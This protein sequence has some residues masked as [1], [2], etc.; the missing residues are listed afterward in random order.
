[1][2][3]NAYA[4][5]M[6][7]GKG[8][9]F[10]PLSTSCRPK[11]LLSLVGN[12]PLVTQAVDRMKGLIP[13][14]RIFVITSSALAAVTR[15]AVPSLPPANIVGEPVP[16]DT[17]AVCA[18]GCALVKARDASAALCILTA[19]HAIGDIALFR[20]TLEAAF[21]SA[22]QDDVLVTIGMRPTAP[23]TGYGYIE[24]GGRLPRRRGIEFTRA[25]RFVE[26]PDLKTARR[27]IASGR[28]RWNSGMFVWSVASFMK[29]LAAHQPRLH[30]MAERISDCVGS[31]GFAAR[32]RDEYARLDRISVDYAVMEKA[33]NIVMAT[34]TFAW[35]DVG[36]WAALQAH[37]PSDGAG[38]AIAGACEQI[39]SSGNIVVS[40]G[41]LTALLGVVGL[42]VVQAPGATLV[43]AR[44]RAQDVKK[45]VA[46]LRSSGRYD[47]LL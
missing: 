6:A 35:D 42:V 47:R 23:S 9:R 12:S 46:T 13:P 22:M 8:E 40:G 25:K 17:A 4:V 36:S 15:K 16:R 27:Y 11:Q 24:V 2:R 21:D 41:R 37:L 1:M 5:I 19:D 38:N 31:R 30:A 20:R 33:R 34:G 45:L 3:A 18:L 32:M 26:K 43:C 28:F 7:G 29:A 44:D 39:D 10:W 14:Q